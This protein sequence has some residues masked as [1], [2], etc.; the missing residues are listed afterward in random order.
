MPEVS[1][2]QAGGRPDTVIWQVDDVA[3]LIRLPMLR[4]LFVDFNSFFASVEQQERPELRGRPVAVVPVEVDTTCAIAASYEAKRFGVKTGT[5]IADAKRMCPDLVLVKAHH[6]KYVEYHHRLVEV[7]E[8]VIHVKEVMSIDEMACELTGSARQREKAMAIAADVKRAIAEQVGP[9]MR[10]SIGIAPND[11]LA[12]TASDMQKPDGLVVIDDDDLPH[13][14]YRLELQDLCGIGK[15]MFKRCYRAGIYTV[16]MLCNAPKHKLHE[17]WGGI[18]GDRMWAKLRGADMPSLP[19]RKSVVGHSHVLEPEHRTESGAEAV[20]HRLLQKAATRL[21]SYG[22]LSGHMSIK[23]RYIDGYR[24]KHGMDFTAT[25]DIIQFTAV[26]TRA[27]RERVPHS[28]TP[29]KVDIALDDLMFVDAAPVPLF[30]NTGP[31]REDLNSAL[32]KLNKKHGKNTI[33]VGTAHAALH[34]APLRIAFNHIPDLEL[35]D[36][37]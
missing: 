5:I 22:M 1:G 12:K 15:Q 18:E 35:D 2:K 32:D 8:S 7:V 13:V 11:Y 19:T 34:S 6:T 14:L 24:W 20:L 17:I 16:E 29:L 23:I 37:D 30:A 10:C 4:S 21:R 36:D 25:Q 31:A 28:G 9:E 3:S 26:L 33:Y 27:L